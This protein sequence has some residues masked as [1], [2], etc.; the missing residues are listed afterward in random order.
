VQFTLIPRLR[1]TQEA[2]ARRALVRRESTLVAAPLV[3]GSA[4]IWL[5]AP[6]LAH[7]LLAGRY[8]LS[9]ALITVMLFS[10]WLKLLNGFLTAVVVSCGEEQRLRWLSVICWSTL[11]ISVAGAFLG[12]SWGLVGVLLGI[13]AGWLARCLLASWLA[14]AC[15]REPRPYLRV[16]G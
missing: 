13:A 6:P 7:W 2:R 3:V 12:I 9:E 16:P 14:V 10:G 5:L 4:A 15:L 11:A 1:Q 8:D